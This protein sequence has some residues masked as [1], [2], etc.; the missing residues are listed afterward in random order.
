MQS[1]SGGEIKIK[2]KVKRQSDSFKIT[3]LSYREHKE[4]IYAL[5]IKQLKKQLIKN[6][7]GSDTDTLNNSQ[8]DNISVTSVINQ[9][10]MGESNWPTINQ[11]SLEKSARL[12]QTYGG[13]SQQP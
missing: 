8:T 10:M 1:S 9:D 4:H 13:T 6:K 12:E 3:K 11:I 7:S 2:Q 5:Q